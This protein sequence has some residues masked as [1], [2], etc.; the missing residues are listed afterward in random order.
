MGWIRR[1]GCVATPLVTRTRT[2]AHCPPPAPHRSEGYPR[3]NNTEAAPVRGKTLFQDV[4]H[5]HPLC[6]KNHWQWKAPVRPDLA[7][8]IK[9]ALSHGGGP[10]TGPQWIIEEWLVSAQIKVETVDSELTVLCPIGLEQNGNNGLHESSAAGGECSV[11]WGN[12]RVLLKRQIS[13]SRDLARIPL[14]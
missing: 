14:E 4:S 9:A 3:A 11:L 1:G 6:V 2:L 12:D 5:P 8:A 10:Q 7:V 13:F